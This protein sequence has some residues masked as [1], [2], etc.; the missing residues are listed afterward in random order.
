MSGTDE[1]G[2]GVVLRGFTAFGADLR[3]RQ[4]AR[5]AF[6]LSLAELGGFTWTE[7]G[8]YCSVGVPHACQQFADHRQLP[9][10]WATQ[11]TLGLS[12]SV[13]GSVTFSLGAGV[14][15][16][17]LVDGE[18]LAG[19]AAERNV[20]FAFGSIQRLGLRTLPLI[21]VLVT[22]HL[23]IDAYA[24]GA[25]VRSQGG[26]VETYMAGMSYEH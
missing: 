9:T 3:Y 6:N 22:P 5:H 25:Y 2:D 23:G 19:H 18:F 12:E 17:L 7:S 20:V 1:P 15:A 10:T 13:P 11:F 26:W 21:H 16:N 8:R 14:A 24:V 4:S